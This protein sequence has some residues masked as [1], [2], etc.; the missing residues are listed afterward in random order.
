[1]PAGVEAGVANAMP[2]G[3]FNRVYV[4]GLPSGSLAST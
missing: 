2:R 1:M 4:K 3:G